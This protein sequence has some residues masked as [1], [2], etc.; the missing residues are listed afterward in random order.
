VPGGAVPDSTV[1]GGAVPDSTVTGGAGVGPNAQRG[2][3]P[4]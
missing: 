1:T 4:V 3:P 2:P